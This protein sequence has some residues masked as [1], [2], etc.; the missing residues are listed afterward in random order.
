[1]SVQSIVVAAGVG[2]R[3]GAPV[4][5]ALVDVGGVPLLV[6]TLLRLR[7]VPELTALP[8]IVTI[9]EDHRTAFEQVLEAAGIEARLIAGGA[10]RQDSVL[11]AVEA[12]APDTEITLIHDAARPFVPAAS[13]QAS[14]D[15][16]RE[17]GAAT[18]AIPVTDTIL[19]ADAE[20]YLQGTPDRSRLWACQTPQTF[21]HSVILDAHHRA[22]AE[23]YCGTDDASLVRRYGSAVRLVMGHP[24]NIK[25]TRPEDLPMA[26]RILEDPSWHT[27]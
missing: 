24:F 26:Q 20:G 9:P 4:P 2:A 15:A 27:A 1:M 14:I 22:H 8:P 13:V 10:E 23:G 3:L 21:R 16:A 18:V 17:M 19:E 12:A 11:L 5:K 25:I 7:S 6:R